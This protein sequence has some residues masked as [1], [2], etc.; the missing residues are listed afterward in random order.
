M[1]TDGTILEQ[2]ESK[3]GYE[4]ES[5][6]EGFFINNGKEILHSGGPINRAVAFSTEL[7]KETKETKN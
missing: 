1:K 4:S 6:S 7:P 3:G 2:S 5:F